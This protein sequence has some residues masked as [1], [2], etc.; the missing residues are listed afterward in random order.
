MLALSRREGQR[1]VLTVKTP[2]RPDIVVKVELVKVKTMRMAKLGIE[3][4][5]CVEIL[6]EE[7]LPEGTKR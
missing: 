6:R 7:L 4:P 5:G 3:A 2:D 1:L